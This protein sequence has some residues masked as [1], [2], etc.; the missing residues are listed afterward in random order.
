MGNQEGV[1]FSIQ[2]MSRGGDNRKQLDFPG[3]CKTVTQHNS[4]LSKLKE[5][6]PDFLETV[7]IPSH[8]PCS[9]NIIILAPHLFIFYLLQLSNIF[10]RFGVHLHCY[11][12]NTQIYISSKPDS[13]LPTSSR[14]HCLSLIKTWFTLNF[15]KLDSEKSEHFL[16]KSTLSRVNSL[17]LTIDSY[18]GF[19]SAQVQSLVS[20]SRTH[21]FPVTHQQ[22]NAICFLSSLE[23]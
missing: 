16:T 2:V 5:G 14:T 18:R 4:K 17:S 8:S 15:L 7:K 22:Y 21:S 6:W 10:R 12:N 9:N 3:K 23:H 1:D 20:S 13:S 19:P 11:E